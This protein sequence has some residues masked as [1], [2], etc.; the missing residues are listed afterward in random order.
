MQPGYYAPPPELP[1][2]IGIGDGFLFG[3]G[4]LLAGLLAS[5]GMVVVM[6]LLNLILGPTIL[7]GL[8]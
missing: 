3:C 4:F 5:I 6:I 8:R 2:K 7:Q 1:A